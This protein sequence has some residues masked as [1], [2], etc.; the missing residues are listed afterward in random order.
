MVVPLTFTLTMVESVNVPLPLKPVSQL[1]PTWIGVPGVASRGDPSDAHV[2]GSHTA[3]A[4][5]VP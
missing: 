5:H 2:G 3:F 1:C 4:H